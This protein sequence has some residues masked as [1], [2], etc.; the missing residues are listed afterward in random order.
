MLAK[1][2]G[3]EDALYLMRLKSL[4]HA[5][6]SK[7]AKGSVPRA[8]QELTRRLNLPTRWYIHTLKLQDGKFENLEIIH[9]TP[10]A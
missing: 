8:K 1:L 7:P 9:L 2:S 6:K 4:S 5:D 3:A 10:A